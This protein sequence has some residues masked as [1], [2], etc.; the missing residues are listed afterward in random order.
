MGV[1]A[2]LSGAK[3]PARAAMA[4]APSLLLACWSGNAGWL[5][6]AI[7]TIS[8][9]VAMERSGLAPLG[10]ALQGLAIMLGFAG[11]LCARACA[12]LFVFACAAL[13]GASV[14]L[15]GCGAGLRSAGNFT[16]IPALYLA[17]ESGEKLAPHALPVHDVAFLPLAVAAL[18]PA[19]ALSAVL[20]FQDSES[21]TDR[22]RHWGRLRRAADSGAKAP[23]RA[24]AMTTALAVAGAAALAQC[25]HLG[26]AQWLI[27]SAASVVTGDA[28]SA[29]VKLRERALGAIAGVPVGIGIGPFVP[30]NLTSYGLASLAAMLTLVGIR[31][32]VVGFGLRCAF[33]ALAIVIAGHAAPIAAERLINVLLG[34]IIGIV[35]VFG[36]HAITKLMP[37]A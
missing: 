29:G 1:L 21:A 9:L 16:F 32:Y 14:L 31:R 3:L 8:M 33:S 26:H 19:I 17:C 28:G 36:A 18:M 4:L 30:H 27:W 5:R 35:A 34:G 6:A 15:T 12:P 24:V 37:D 10:V 13:A 7:V 20:H 11:L 2:P 23:W 22:L 25:C